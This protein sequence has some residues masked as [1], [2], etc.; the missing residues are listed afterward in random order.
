VNAAIAVPAGSPYFAGHFPGRPILPGVAL[1]ALVVATLARDA[2]RPAALRAIPFAR[3]RRPVLPGDRL[4][5]ETRTGEAGRVRVEVSRDGALVAN[6]ELVLGPPESHSGAAPAAAAPPGSAAPPPV[7]RLVPQH[8]PMR[9]VTA[10]VG[11]AAD[12]LACAAQIPSA[13]AL[14]S[15]GTAPAL[16]ALE[17]AAQTA[18]AWEAVQRWREARDAAPRMGYLVAL[19]DVGFFADRIPADEMLLA[20]VRL[21]A[22]APP[23]THYAVEVALGTAPIVRGTIATFLADPPPG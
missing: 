7:D 10:I 8:P 2:G 23:L 22:A 1:L 18:A 19:R 15:Q 21:A 13:C 4:A 17:A 9:F 3:L 6:G 5:L 20:S 14:V 12:G 16:A 11:E